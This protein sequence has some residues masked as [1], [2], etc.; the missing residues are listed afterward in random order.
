MEGV[1]GLSTLEFDLPTTPALKVCTG[2][3]MACSNTTYN[4][5]S[6]HAGLVVRCGYL[7]PDGVTFEMCTPALSGGSDWRLSNLSLVIRSAP[8]GTAAVHMRRGGSGFRMSQVNVSLLQANVSN[9]LWAGSET[10]GPPVE[11]VSDIEIVDSIL[12]QYGSCLGPGS[13]YQGVVLHV[14]LGSDLRVRNTTVYWR[15]GWE[16]VD[17]FDRVIIEDNSIHCIVLP[18]EM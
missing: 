16:D 13:I 7:H 6:F 3:S 8:P 18:P 14:E 15:C 9:A 11:S 1:S 4:Y 10:Q 2:P 5:T 12:G 17:V